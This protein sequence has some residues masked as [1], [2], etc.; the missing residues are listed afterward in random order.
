MAN[1]TFVIFVLWSIIALYGLSR[2][3][4]TFIVLP[5]CVVLYSIFSYCRDRSNSGEDH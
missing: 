2:G 5:W 1:Q 4:D 3:F